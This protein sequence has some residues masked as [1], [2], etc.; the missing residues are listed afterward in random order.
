MENDL[1]EQPISHLLLE[2]KLSSKDLILASTESITYKMVTRAC[3][4]R[5]LNPHVQAK[6]C[7]AL[8]SATGKKFTVK[9]LFNY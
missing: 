7:N 2:L 6:I 3:K 1:G 4:G 5:R 9:D 8:N